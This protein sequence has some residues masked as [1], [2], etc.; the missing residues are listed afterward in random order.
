MRGRCCT[1]LGIFCRTLFLPTRLRLRFACANALSYS[2]AMIDKVGYSR[3]T[4]PAARA[5]QIKKS[6]AA[7]GASFASA[8]AGAQATSDIDAPAPIA[9][10]TGLGSLLGAQEVSEEELHRRK[11]I[12]SGRLALE[13][14]EQLRD[15]MLTGRLSTATLKQLE[16][17]VKTERTLTT[18]ARLNAVLDDIELRAAVELAKLEM[19][20]LR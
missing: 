20:G 13:A 10:A 4:T 11:S 7:G 16:S 14:L 8:L 6:S 15:A 2:S 3:P 5:A 9:P 18:D 19:S 1:R 12:R 17:L